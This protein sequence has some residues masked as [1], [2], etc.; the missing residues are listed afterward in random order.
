MAILLGVALSFF[1]PKAT[2]VSGIEW[3]EKPKHIVNFSLQTQTGEYNR[4]SL[5]G[6]FTIVWFGFLECVDVCPLALMQASELAKQL[7]RLGRESV[8][9]SFVFVSVDPM[10][11]STERITQFVTYFDT[12]FVG[13]TADKLALERFTGSLGVRFRVSS[14]EQ[15]YS[16]SHSVMFSVIAPDGTLV[17]RFAPDFDAKVLARELRIKMQ[18]SMSPLQEK[19]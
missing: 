16:V 18:A 1:A 14:T 19:S 7:R 12:S 11:D 17:G 13:A 15:N 5:L 9:I 10:R 8:P 4:Q 3:L 2:S 6:R